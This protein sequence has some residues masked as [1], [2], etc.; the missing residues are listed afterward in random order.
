MKRSTRQVTARLVRRLGAPLGAAALLLALGMP[1]TL[2]QGQAAP[3][4]IAITG[5]NQLI[6]FSGTSPGTVS[7][8]VDVTGLQS[9]ESIQG[10]DVRP[11]NGKLYAVGSSGR[12]YTVDP[13][14]GAATQSG[15]WS[16][17]LNGAAFG[18]DFNPVPDRLRVVSDGDQNL[19]INVD[20]AEATVDGTLKYAPA[21]PN[22]GAN[23]TVVAAGYTNSMAGAQSTSLFV[24]DS[25]LDVLARQDPPNDGVLNTIGKLG[26]D[27]SSA[28]GFDVA[29]DGNRAFAALTT[30]GGSGSD[31][32]S[33]DLTTGAATRVG[34]IG[35]GQ[36][37]RG[38]AAI[39]PMAA[40]AQPA[41]P[42]PAAKPAAP[43]GAMQM[44]AALPRAGEA[45]DRTT[46][47]AGLAS[48]GAGLLLTGGALAVRRRRA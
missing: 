7:S 1:P 24:I 27:V 44:P 15:P 18:V 10:V 12:L 2:A 4:L 11:A 9:G 22:A 21:D 42:A 30:A 37:I 48:V 25:D 40:A 20:T 3:N 26:V 31:L 39:L 36:A 19:R 8:T 23:P 6:R 41:Q 13:T 16:L 32:Y 29:P 38:L 43:A 17:T 28:A 5:N 33:I 45:E 35:N 14:S 46:A 34:P 47:L